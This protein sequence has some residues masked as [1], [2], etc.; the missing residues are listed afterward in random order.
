MATESKHSIIKRLKRKNRFLAINY[1]CLCGLLIV[2]LLTLGYIIYWMIPSAK[3]TPKVFYENMSQEEIETA[4]SI[5]NEIK[6]LYLKTTY[7]IRFTKNI[8]QYC[9]NGCL[10]YNTRRRV[11]TIFDPD[12]LMRTKIVLCHEL[13]HSIIPLGESGEEYVEDL[14]DYLPCYIQVGGKSFP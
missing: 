9:D 13:L 2:T 10:G 11:T 12:N 5:L 14:D 4:N 7:S 6:P 8:S 1:Y 3:Y